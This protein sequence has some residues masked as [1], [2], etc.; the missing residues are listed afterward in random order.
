MESVFCQWS[1]SETEWTCLQCGAVVS[2]QAVPSR[3]FAACR[4]GAEK[5]GVPFRDIIDASRVKHRPSLP[6]YAIAGPGTELKK[7]LSRLRLRAR[8]GCKCN[9][10]MLQMNSWG[11]DECER[12][13]AQIVEWLREE[14][15]ERNLPFVAAGAAIIVRMAIKR[16]RKANTTDT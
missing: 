7:L 8:P 5:N 13:I 6:A 15:T 4:V 16:A 1:E 9:S 10:R 11:A 14:A 3:P 12:R 2:R